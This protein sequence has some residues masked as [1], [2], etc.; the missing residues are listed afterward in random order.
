MGSTNMVRQGLVLTVHLCD[1]RSGVDAWSATIA[2]EG[3]VFA[4][5]LTVAIFYEGR[6]VCVGELDE[7]G[8]WLAELEDLP[9]PFDLTAQTHFEVRTKVPPSSF[10]S[11]KFHP[12]IVASSLK[13][14]LEKSRTWPKD[15]PLRGA[16]LQ[17]VILSQSD[18]KGVDLTGANL[19]GA[20]FWGA[21]LTGAILREAQ[22]DQADFSSATLVRADLQGA[23]AKDTIWGEANLKGSDLR[24]VQG[25]SLDVLQ[26]WIDLATLDEAQIA[27]V[28]LSN[29]AKK[30][31]NTFSSFIVIGNTTFYSYGRLGSNQP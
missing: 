13:G 7:W 27:R 25:L 29:L 10:L 18:L 6:K 28:K 4:Q 24:T 16:L 1:L 8:H 2:I 22:L 9:P 23:S 12:P 17:G 14:F 3:P 26:N 21:N 19:T 31:E 30:K 11:P 5:G 15:L 20:K